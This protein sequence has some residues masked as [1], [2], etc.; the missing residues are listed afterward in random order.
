MQFYDHAYVCI[1]INNVGR[2]RPMSIACIAGTTLAE[3]SYAY[4]LPTARSR[5]YYLINFLSLYLVD[6]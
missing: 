2:R 4:Y 3:R 1:H 6:R 5:N